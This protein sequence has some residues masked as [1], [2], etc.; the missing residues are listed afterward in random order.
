MV[1]TTVAAAL[2]WPDL[3]P[4]PMRAADPSSPGMAGAAVPAYRLRGSGMLGK[5]GS[6]TCGLWS[7]DD[8]DLVEGCNDG[9]NKLP[10]ASCDNDGL[11]R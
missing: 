1:V 6:A 2:D 9:A 11:R 7:D 3:S 10:A 4:A 8:D 5:S